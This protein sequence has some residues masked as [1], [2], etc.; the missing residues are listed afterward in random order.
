MQFHPQYFYGCLIS[1]QKLESP[2]KALAASA[3]EVGFDFS[4]SHIS[5]RTLHLLTPDVAGISD[6]TS[7]SL[8][9]DET[10]FFQ[11]QVKIPLPPKISKS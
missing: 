10:L 5:T 11:L 3:T 6:H 8:F 2:L 7:S 9:R 1:A 4:L